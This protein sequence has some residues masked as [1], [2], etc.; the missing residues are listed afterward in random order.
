MKAELTSVLP[1]INALLFDLGPEG[2]VITKKQYDT[3]MQLTQ[4]NELINFAATGALSI[5]YQD[6]WYS[7]Y[8]TTV[9][10]YGRSRGITTTYRFEL[11]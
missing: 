11:D 2:G 10:R 8:Q 7:L 6:R 5:K 3:L 9:E 4:T 1:L